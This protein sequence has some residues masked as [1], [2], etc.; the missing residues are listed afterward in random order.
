MTSLNIIAC[1]RP[2]ILLLYEP[3]SPRAAKLPAGKFRE[4]VERMTC[5]IIAWLS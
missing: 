5:Y 4:A 1:V 2:N 3:L